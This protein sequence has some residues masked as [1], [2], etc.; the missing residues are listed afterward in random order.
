V[1]YGKW[2]PKGFAEVV[3][4]DHIVRTLKN[5]LATGQVAHAYLFSGPRGTGKTTTA[6]ILARAVNCRGPR[7]GEPCNQCDACRAILSGSALD[8]IEMDAA[9]NRGIDDVRELRERIAYA[10]S[11]LTRKVYLLDEVHMLTE[12]AFNALLKTLEEPPP[13]A[14]FILATTDL[15]KVPATIISRC[16][17]YDFHR[18]P[19]AAI[20][21][22]LAYICEQEGWSVPGE[23]LLAIA[24]QSRG[25]LRDAITMLEQVFA[26]YGANPTIDDVRDALGQVHDERVASLTRAL[27]QSDLAA[28]LEISRSVAD[29][30]LDIARFTRGVIDQVRGLLAAVLREGSRP[31]DAELLATART[32]PDAVQVLVQAL[33]EL[34]RAD[35]RLDPAS[36][37][38]LE[39]ACAAAI[40]GPAQPV[41]STA[42]AAPAATAG[43][44]QAREAPASGPASTGALTREERFAR[45]LYE[46][47]KMVNPS[48]AMWLN[49]S[50]EVLQMDGEELILGFQRKMPL[51]KVDTSC[52]PMVEA[53]AAAILGREVSLKVVLVEGTSQPQREPR[54]GHLVEAAKSMGGRPV[55]KDS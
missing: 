51:E 1:L 46:H 2:R 33:S 49:G 22:R 13:H 44:R 31:A 7:D 9:S 29:D 47:C 5:A 3:G 4:Q 11:D 14:I 37:V 52:R 41:G 53:Q 28:A 54:R 12:G 32:R 17:R 34:A 35:F 15:H 45:D 42:P 20:V 16:Q 43:A 39:V 6:R 38:P 24:I 27:L 23:A 48:L 8:L 55:G 26:R 25:G 19:N 21:D 10:P 18:V 36:P 50:F 30:G 40:L